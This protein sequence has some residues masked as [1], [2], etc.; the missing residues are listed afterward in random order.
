[1]AFDNEDTVV[2]TEAFR[3]K[4]YDDLTFADDF[5]FCRVLTERPDLCRDLVEVITGRKVNQIKNLVAQMSEKEYYDGKGVRFD[6]YFEDDEET[7]YDF[8]MQTVLKDNLPRRVRYYQSMIDTKHLRAGK[9]YETLPDSYIVF[10]CLE[11]PFDEDLYK[12]TFHE[13]CEE[14]PDL[15]L[16][17]GKTSIFLNAASSKMKDGE[18]KDFLLYVGKNTVC[19]ELTRKINDEVR[20]VI[21]DQSGRRFYMLL[22]EKLRDAQN[23][24]ESLG[25]KRGVKLG[26][27]QELVNNIDN[28]VLNMPCSLEHACRLLG[29][30]VEEYYAAKGVDQQAVGK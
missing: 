23:I 13:L 21:D 10:I 8:E 25:V 1:M 5:M 7:V 26:R 3:L 15:A 4:N 11:D 28:L 29:S 27:E 20:K 19:S 2:R 18:L 6:V 9:L 24:G 16:D 14:E 30:S 17:D 12:Y 22:E